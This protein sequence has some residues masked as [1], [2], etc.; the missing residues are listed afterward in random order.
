MGAWYPK[1]PE[2]YIG[3]AGFCDPVC[4]VGFTEDNNDGSCKKLL[5]PNLDML[6]PICTDDLDQ[7]NGVCYP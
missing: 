2:N 7:Y 1:C 6:N 5:Y 4:P 3:S